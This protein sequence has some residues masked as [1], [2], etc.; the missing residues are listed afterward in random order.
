MVI[1]QSIAEML[2]QELVHGCQAKESATGGTRKGRAGE[3][4]SSVKCGTECTGFLLGWPRWAGD[5]QPVQKGKE[6]PYQDGGMRLDQMEFVWG[7]VMSWPLGL[8]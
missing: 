8:A 1:A 7:E 2:H 4:T 3:R 5:E 6:P